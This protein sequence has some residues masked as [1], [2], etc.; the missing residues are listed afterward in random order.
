MNQD[1]SGS[2]DAITMPASAADA[3]AAVYIDVA[4]KRDAER[5][6]TEKQI[7]AADDILAARRNCC[8]REGGGQAGTSG[9]GGPRP[10]AGALR[11]SPVIL[12][13]PV[14]RPTGRRVAARLVL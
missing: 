12:R 6:E 1:A 2:P 14:S 7:A 5:Q 3:W 10:D 4:E 11:H 8:R 13:S 9:A